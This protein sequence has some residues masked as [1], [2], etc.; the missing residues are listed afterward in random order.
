MAAFEPKKPPEDKRETPRKPRP[1]EVPK[2]G[3]L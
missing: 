2:D 3:A 1:S